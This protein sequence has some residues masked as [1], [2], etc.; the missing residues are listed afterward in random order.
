[1]ATRFLQKFSS[2][3]KIKDT[4]NAH[5]IGVVDGELY[6]GNGS[7]TARSQSRAR[8][9]AYAADGAISI[10]AGWGLAVLTKAGVGAYTLAA[11]TAAQEGT[12][13]VIT[14]GSANAHVVTAT[15]LI[16]DGVTG[17]GKNTMTFGAFV[18]ASI[19][20]YAYNLHWIVASKN[21]VTVG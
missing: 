6:L 10:P 15:G 14:A 5:G 18:G 4:V 17:G 7:G 19:I 1:M 9:T 20:L 3:T 11:P 13:L 21:I 8:V 2:S 16:D 12:E